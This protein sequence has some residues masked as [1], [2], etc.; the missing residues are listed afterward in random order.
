MTP[1]KKTVAVFFGGRSP[2]HDVSIITGLQV[3]E[4][5]DLRHFDAFPVYISP[6]GEWFT[7]DALRSKSNYLLD[8]ATK[9]KLTQVRLDVTPRQGKGALIPLKSGSLFGGG[10]K[11]IL[12]D[13]ALPSFHGLIGEDGAFQGV[14]ELANIPYAGMRQ[15]AS[16]VF[17]DKMTTKYALADSGVPV[18]PAAVIHRPAHGNLVDKAALEAMLK[19]VGYPCCIKPVHLGSSIG[20]G[21]ANNVDEARAI[22]A[23]LFQ[24]DMTAMAEP[25]VANLTEYNVSVRKSGGKIVTSA[26]EKPKTSAELLDFKEKYLSNDGKSGK[27]APSDSSEGMLSLTRDI[28][29]DLPKGMEAKIREW[30]T[31]VFERLDGTGGPRIDFISDGKTNEIWFNE[32][33]PFPGSC[34]YFLWNAAKNDAAV[35]P[36]L[37]TGFLNEALEEWTRAQLPDD[38]TPQDARLFKRR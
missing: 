14:M 27:K 5:I 12:F 15:K 34:A 10:A 32:L 20:V 2:E 37:L 4:A 8:D 36:E 21:K 18:L 29:P 6:R 35:F 38:P 24:Y 22:L 31:I 26:I 19:P 9:A 30:A 23:S 17:M 16:A 3:L 11:P 33:N 7:G 28:N 13:I 1:S 25:F